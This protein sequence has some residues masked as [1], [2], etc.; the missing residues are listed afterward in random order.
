MKK[1]IRK[2]GRIEYSEFTIGIGDDIYH[3]V[4]FHGF[5]GVVMGSW[6]S[7]IFGAGENS[8]TWLFNGDG[9]KIVKDGKE[10]ALVHPDGNREVIGHD[11]DK[12]NGIQMSGVYFSDDPD[13]GPQWMCRE[14]GE[15]LR[16][17]KA[18][19]CKDRDRCVDA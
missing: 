16:K 14:D 15:N 1:V 8:R 5:P 12:S 6:D 18:E 17:A 11:D 19:A 10:F 3:E 13:D 9:V 4:G 2:N 7:A